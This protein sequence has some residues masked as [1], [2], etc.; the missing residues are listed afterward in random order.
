MDAMVNRRQ[1]RNVVLCALMAALA[2]A[3]VRSAWV[4]PER[5]FAFDFSINYTG[6]RL[7]SLFHADRPLYDRLTL[8]IEASP[9]NVYPALYTQLYLTYIQTPATAVLTYPLA[10]LPFD[11]ARTVY[12]ALSDLLFVGAAALMVWALRPSWLLALAAFA[13]FGT[14][15]P[16]FDSLRLGQVDALIVFGLAL[17]FVLLR[18]GP[19]PLAGAPLAGAVIL[20]LS[21]AV[22]LG[23]F[24]VRRQ[25]RIVAVAVVTGA[26]LL[27]ISLLVAGWQNHI[28]FVRDIMPGL[29]K[30]SSFY[31]NVSI[32][33]AVTRA[34]L[35]RD[36]WYYQDELPA[37][38][39]AL[40][41]AML[42]LSA[43]IVLG[44]YALTRRDEETGF[45]LSVVVALLISPVA[46]SHYPTWLIPSMLWLARRY[47]DRRA[48]RSFV[49]F[50]VL[51]ALL[52]VVPAHYE[53]LNPNLYAIPVKTIALVLYGLLLLRE[54]W[55]PRGRTVREPSIRARGPL[56]AGV[57]R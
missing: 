20:K 11:Q 26:V 19:R 50:V 57:P 25:W 22:V 17:A 34:Y 13:I 16:M 31:D 53:Q 39:V 43:G 45:M 47:E 32:N 36:F 24:V 41:L 38:P 37:L 48:W 14:F 2:L 28:T 29:M 4:M 44:A 42:A 27:G 5:N 40:R 9:Y 52:A 7:L 46:W 1:V 6:A 21:P 54:A 56:R 8:T 23:Y 35:G 12:L 49:A 33:G 55:L 15:E 51:Y 18:R 3:W 10:Q 30:G